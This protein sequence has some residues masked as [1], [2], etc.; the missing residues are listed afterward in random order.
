MFTGFK[1]IS[2]P[3][4]PSTFSNFK[5]GV[6]SPGSPTRA[7]RTTR[8]QGLA[9]CVSIDRLRCGDR[10]SEQRIFANTIFQT[11]GF[12]RLYLFFILSLFGRSIDRG[13][14]LLA[15]FFFVLNFVLLHKH[16]CALVRRYSTTYIKRL[17]FV[18]K[19]K[20]YS[21]K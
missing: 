18:Y 19:T 6:R 1:R 14:A 5:A 4:F 12:L 17:Q 21:F 8:R 10:T 9:A 11:Y 16:A 15:P 2:A 3:F 20:M 7:R 13:G